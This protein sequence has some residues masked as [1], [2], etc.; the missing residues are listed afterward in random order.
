MKIWNL[1]ISF[2]LPVPPPSR[3]FLLTRERDRSAI[4]EI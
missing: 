4:E 3:T 1:V 2:A